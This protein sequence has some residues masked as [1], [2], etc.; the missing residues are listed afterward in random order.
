MMHRQNNAVAS[1]E[2]KL[3]DMLSDQRFQKKHAIPYD[4]QT[5]IFDL[6]PTSRT[7]H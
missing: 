1:F 3:S 6:A 2:K 5:Q 7:P 4:I